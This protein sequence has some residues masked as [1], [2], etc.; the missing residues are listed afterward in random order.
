MPLEPLGREIASGVFIHRIHDAEGFRVDRYVI[1][2]HATAS[3][4]HVRCSRRDVDLSCRRH[5]SWRA[6]SMCLDAANPFSGSRERVAPGVHR[7]RPRMTRGAGE[8]RIRV[9]AADDAIGPRTGYRASQPW[10]T[11]HEDRTFIG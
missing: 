7:R 10:R 11:I 3:G 4:D 8:D 9:R 5:E 6:A 1:K 2:A